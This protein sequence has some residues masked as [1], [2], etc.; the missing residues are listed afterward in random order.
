MLDILGWSFDREGPKSDDFSD[1]VSALGVQF[2]L[3]D[4][5]SGVLNICNTEKRICETLTLLDEVMAKGTLQ[6]RE[7]L[8]LRGRLAFCDAFVF[9]RLGKIALQD[10]TKHAY[11][12]PF[13]EQLAPT[14]LNSMKLLRSRIA[15]GKPR[16][17]TCELLE[18]LFLFTDASFEENG[19]AGLGA[20]LVNGAG[21]VLAWFG[22]CLNQEQLA[23]FLSAGQ[24]TI[25]GELET[26]AVALSLLVWQ[27]LL[28]SVQLMVYIDNEGSKF[29]LIKGYS[30]SRAT[31]EG[32]CLIDAA[33]L[34]TYHE[35][36]T[37]KVT[38]KTM[39]QSFNADCGFQAF[40]WIGAIL[41]EQMPVPMPPQHA[42][43]WRYLFAAHL[44]HTE[45]HLHKIDIIYLGGTKLNLIYFDNWLNC[46]NSM[47]FGLTGQMKGLPQSLI[48]CL[49]QPYAKS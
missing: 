2:L 7:A 43:E 16:R 47:V 20:V 19:Q 44:L 9:G 35:G 38:Q 23:P 37:L 24:Q 1:V 13:R 8:T 48:G 45:Q 12:N 40:A 26:L 21:K 39:P 29:S 34:V 41:S 18:T 3:V 42:A 46:S 36:Y 27:N 4:T 6:K 15:E 14:T 33:A 17:L 28:E 49:V 25:I 22:M 10:I 11:N 32:S 30:T 31:P 5:C